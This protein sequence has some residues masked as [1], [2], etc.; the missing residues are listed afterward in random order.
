MLES[1]Q[2]LLQ[3]SNLFLKT[4]N[5]SPRSLLFSTWPFFFFLRIIELSVSS[6]PIPRFYSCS[7][8]SIN[9]TSL[10]FLLKSFKTIRDQ[11]T[12]MM[13]LEIELGLSVARLLHGWLWKKRR[14]LSK[15]WMLFFSHYFVRFYEL[16]LSR[17]TD[18]HYQSKRSLTIH[19]TTSH[20]H[21]LELVSRLYFACLR[22]IPPTIAA[23]LLTFTP[24]S[25]T[26]YSLP[27][28]IPANLS[29]FASLSQ[30]QPPHLETLSS[31]FCPL[32]LRL[33]INFSQQSGRPLN[34]WYLL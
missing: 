15:G 31:S 28:K 26:F 9:E 6:S 23:F 11:T 18:Y 4:F 13:F 1:P 16:I 10:N 22:D 32:A 5:L 8:L 7:F 2:F 21:Y 12:F 30:S 17:W 14:W 33:Y 24:L 34:W 29:S 3:W 19:R 25:S 20:I 27:L